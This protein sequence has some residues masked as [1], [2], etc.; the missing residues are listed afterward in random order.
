[1]IKSCSVWLGEFLRPEEPL[2]ILRTAFRIKYLC[3]VM[4]QDTEIT[5]TYNF[6]TFFY[7]YII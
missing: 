7:P 2:I 1:M 6:H 4:N 5:E 3:V